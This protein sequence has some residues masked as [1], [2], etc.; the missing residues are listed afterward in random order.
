MTITVLISKLKIAKIAFSVSLTGA[1]SGQP[2]NAMY[3]LAPSGGRTRADRRAHHA[4]ERLLHSTTV[5]ASREATVAYPII[6]RLFDPHVL[7][8]ESS[9]DVGKP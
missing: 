3:E 7:R 1:G 2:A 6:K 8:Y 4:V 5:N 9:K